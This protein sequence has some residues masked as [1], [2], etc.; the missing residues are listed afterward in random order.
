MISSRQ[1][2]RSAVVAAVFAA[3][4][5]GCATAADEA[6]HDLP[7]KDSAQWVMPLDEYQFPSASQVENYAENLLVSE[8]MQEAGFRWPIA[9]VPLDD[10]DYATS[11]PMLTL[12]AAQTRGYHAPLSADR[13][14][15]IEELTKMNT[16]AQSQPGFDAVLTPCL[17]KV[18][19]EHPLSAIMS[20]NF[21]LGGMTQAAE[22]AASSP[23]VIS[24]ADAWREC[25]DDAGYGGA[26]N[27]PLDGMPTNEMRAQ[28]GIPTYAP[29]VDG[30][31]EPALVDAE[32]ALA[33][34]DV[35]CRESSGWA[36][37]QYDAQ[38]DRQVEFI[39]A[40]ADRL[41]RDRDAWLKHRQEL[42]TLIAA[43]APAQG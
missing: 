30:P 35:D 1:K 29:G 37:A 8:C 12:E 13:A 32:V 21:L 20:E 23:A 36:Q 38:W 10:A 6:G 27:S 33:T 3:L 40:N 43:H 28:L 22:D 25:L 9:P 17:E 2:M 41:S 39:R 16:L 34:A 15:R 7:A 31:A 18:R 11:G 14:A 5:S 24:A 26:P 42:L 4:V 19:A